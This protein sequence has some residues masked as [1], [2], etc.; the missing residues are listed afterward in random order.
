MKTL[1]LGLLLTVLSL[2]VRNASAE[3]Q[4]A[5]PD[6]TLKALTGVNLRLAEQ[7]GDIIVLNFWASW[8]GPC[9]QEMPALDKLASKYQ[10]LGV[11]IWGV[12]VEADSTAAQ[13]YLSKTRVEFPIL[14]DTENSVSERY[15]VQAMPTT[16]IINKDGNVHSVHRGYKPGYE[17]KY[18]NDIK[19]LLRN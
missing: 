4:A 9:L 12:N 13:K 3:S 1:L 6:F 5:A 8:C 2:S 7:R 15:Q 14:F 11:Q 16:V 19:T 18:E 17:Q 10:P